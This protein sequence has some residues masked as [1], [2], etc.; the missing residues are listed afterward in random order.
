MKQAN[1][2]R[3]TFIRN[4]SL[5]A[6][7]SALPGSLL[8][9]CNPVPGVQM[10]LGLVTYLWAKDWDIPTII[11]NCTEAQIGGVELRVE[12]AH[13]VTLDLTAAQRAEVKKQFADSPVEI[14]GMGTNQDYHS[15]DP[16]KLKESIETTKQW[17]QLS[18][19]IGGSGVK[20]KPNAFPEGVPHEKTI[21]QIGKALNELGQ[22]AL[23]LGQVIRLEV[24]G[25]E[26]Q[27]L[28]NIKA[29]M[30]YVD[31]KGTGV[32]WNCNPEDLAG[33]GLEYNFN[34]VKDRFSDIC[35]VREMNEGDYPYQELMNLFVK[36]DYPG[37]ILLEC[38]TDPA[39]KVAAL[40][41]QRRVWLDMIA[42]AKE[43]LKG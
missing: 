10:K 11:R 24:H 32:C 21:E 40:K 16:A 1:Q 3:R 42:K 2:N 4:L 17:L 15:P 22:Y 29:M 13:G 28:P 33:Q 31:N 9:A 37:W 38:R 30:D 23:D 8:A 20:V 26:T 34:L 39:D 12:H 5:I 7:A 19:D 18:K 41:E 6:G 36:M 43:G 27:L 35:H 14:I 25:R